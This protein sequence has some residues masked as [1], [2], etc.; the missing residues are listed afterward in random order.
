ML[1]DVIGTIGTGSS[2]V[3]TGAVD[4]STNQTEVPS[5]PPMGAT[6]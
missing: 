4:A 1:H 3:T 5:F 2:P 6:T